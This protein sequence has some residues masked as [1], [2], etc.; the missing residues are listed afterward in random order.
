[1]NINDKCCNAFGCKGEMQTEINRLKRENQ[2]LRKQGIKQM[3][4][5]QEI[6]ANAPKGATHVDEKG[7]YYQCDHNDNCQWFKWTKQTA[8]YSLSYSN[9]I[10][11]VRSLEDIKQLAALRSPTLK[12]LHDDD[13]Y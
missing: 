3:N 11:N 13:V 1:M 6:L 5:L 4:N 10:S 12:H 9:S 8:G 2:M 7:V